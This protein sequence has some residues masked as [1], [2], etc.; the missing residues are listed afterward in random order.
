MIKLRIEEPAFESSD[1]DLFTGGSIKRIRINHATMNVVSI[2]NAD[3]V[4]KEGTPKFQHG[5]WWYDYFSG[6]SM[7]VTDVN[8]S[9]TMAPGEYHIYTDKHLALPDINV[10]LGKD[11]PVKLNPNITIF[12][13]PSGGTLHISGSLEK[14]GIIVVEIYDLT[15]KVIARIE[16]KGP[17]GAYR[18]DWNGL[19]FYGNSVPSGT[20]IL[21]I[22]ENGSITNRKFVMQR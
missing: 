2:V 11:E 22:N 12:P 16:E 5:G 8:M 1:F 15:G 20:Y 13:N 9:Y 10:A 7:N 19:D 17:A 4:P 3:V 14:A 21:K 6:D 18:M